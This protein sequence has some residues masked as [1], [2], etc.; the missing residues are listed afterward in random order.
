[1]LNIFNSATKRVIIFL[2]LAHL[3]SSSIFADDG[4][5]LF[6]GNCVTCHN[7]KRSI[8]APS[9]KEVRKRY[10]SAFSEKE[11]F[12]KYMS[13]F[14]IKPDENISIMRDKVQKYKIMPILGYEESV[15]KEIATYIFET[16]F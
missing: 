16:Q 12:V 6:N 14:I 13:L 15:A 10:L 9:M 2:M 4:S 11:E 3:F 5:L 7:S 1:M 8:S